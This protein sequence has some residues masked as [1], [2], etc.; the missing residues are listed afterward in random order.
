MHLPLKNRVIDRYA[1]LSVVFSKQ[2]MGLSLSRAIS[3]TTKLPFYTVDG[4]PLT[5]SSRTIYRWFSA[6]KR[7]NLAGITPV[8]RSSNV[9]SRILPQSFIDFM[10]QEKAIDTDASIPDI[11]LRAEIKG[12]TSKGQ[13]KRGAAWRAARR[14]NLPIFSDKRP[15][16]ED[17]RRFA[18]PH[19]MT[20]VLCDGKHF[21]AGPTHRK[22]VVFFYIDD[23]SRKVI[24]AVVGKSENVRLFLRGLHAVIER[25]GLMDG[26]YLDRGPGFRAKIAFTICARIG[27]PLI[28]G[29]ARYPPGHGKIEKFNQTCLNDLLRGIAQDPL[30][31][32]D[33]KSLEHRI[34]HYITAMYNR[35]P[36]EGIAGL[37]PDFKWSSDSRSLRMPG[38]M[39]QFESHFV[40]A[41]RRKVSRDNVV[42]VR[43]IG[44]EMPAGYDGRRVEVYDHT[45]EG[46]LTV[47]HEGKHIKL[48]PVD[49]AAN[50]RAE[51]R[52]RVEKER[53]PGPGPIKTAA[54]SLY[55]RDHKTIVTP[56]GDYYEK[57]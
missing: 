49:L 20:M 13:V 56:G 8:T 6:F 17:M 3:E 50:A 31:D 27:F 32:P 29:R 43:G 45:L 44:Y 47:L 52:R 41:S 34:N 55:E 40:V 1:V 16:G 51:R 38:D 21:C 12:I 28:L 30:I 5:L 10:V 54:Q 19:R 53:P 11:I 36:H 37:T 25:A 2:A 7:G 48:L 26:I 33:C 9:I 23:C 35:R 24:G 15:K 57:D 4:D 39:R 22:R 18:H 46:H 42:M 14:L